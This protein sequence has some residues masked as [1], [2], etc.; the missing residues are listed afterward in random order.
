M[1]F[2]RLLRNSAAQTRNNFARAFAPLRIGRGMTDGTPLIARRFELKS[3]G[4][5]EAILS[6]ESIEQLN[7]MLLMLIGFLM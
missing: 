2:V 4:V 1:R 3:A 7:G 5:P 6:L